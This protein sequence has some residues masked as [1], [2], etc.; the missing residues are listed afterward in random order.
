MTERMKAGKFKAE[1]LK[2]MDRVKKTRKKIISASNMNEFINIASYSMTWIGSFGIW[3]RDLWELKYLDNQ[4]KSSLSQVYMLLKTIE[5]KKH[6]T[7]YKAKLIPRNNLLWG[8]CMYTK[9]F[10]EQS[11]MKCIK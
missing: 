10:N 4:A 8:R 9:E 6:T 1:C 5:N 2:V 3:R 11:T 7:T